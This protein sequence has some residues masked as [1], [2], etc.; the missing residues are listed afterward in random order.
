ML[1][2]NSKNVEILTVMPEL[3]DGK[4]RIFAIQR[5][6]SGDSLVAF[7]C[8]VVT[9]PNGSVGVAE[10]LFLGWTP[11]RV[12][13]TQQRIGEGFESK[14]QVGQV[15]PADILITEKLEPAYPGQNPKANSDG[16]VILRNGVPVYEHATLAPVGQGGIVIYKAEPVNVQAALAPTTATA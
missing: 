16:E 4:T 13:R 6:N 11:E 12:V 15:I 8:Q 5:S 2:K 14:F 10:Q 3:K 1:T 9:N 7:M